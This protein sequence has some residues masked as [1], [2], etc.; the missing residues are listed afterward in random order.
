MAKKN[1]SN[2]ST[3]LSNH[4]CYAWITLIDLG[5]GKSSPSRA[6]MANLEAATPRT[7]EWGAGGRSR[8]FNTRQCPGAAGYVTALA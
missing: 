1:I 8:K 6:A 3:T 4:C 5:R 2:P 7:L